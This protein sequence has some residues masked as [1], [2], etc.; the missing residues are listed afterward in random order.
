MS[1][2]KRKTSKGKTA[3]YHYKFIQSGKTYFGV[4]ENCFKKEKAIDFEKAKIE[5]AK[6]LTVQKSVRALVENF[7]DELTGGCSISLLDAY[8]LSLKKPRKKQPSTDRIKFKRSYW[9]DFTDYMKSIFPDVTS[10]SNVQRKHAEEYIQHIRE[11]GRFNKAVQFKTGKKISCYQRNE[12]LSNASCNVMQQTLCE[13]FDKLFKDA[14]LIENPFKGID[15]LNN[16]YESRDAFTESELKLILNSWDLFIRRI[17]MTGLFTALREGD[18]CTLRKVEIDFNNKIIRR[19]LL[20]TGKLVEIPIMKP[21]EAFLHEEFLLF[22]DSEYIFPELA[23]MYLEN[24]GG[25]SYRVKNFLEGLGIQTTKKLMEGIGLFRLK[26]CIVYGIHFA[27]LQD[28]T[29]FP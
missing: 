4:C 14:G 13:V 26:T 16:N 10:L 2:F 19:K 12:N 3:E 1:V 23:K 29:A 18:I 27:T 7:R 8:E 22:G 9:R 11:K 28:L 6:S 20:K 5:T 24:S 21:L 17:F 25:I 15:K